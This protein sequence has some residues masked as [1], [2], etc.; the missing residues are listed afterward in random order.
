MDRLARKIVAGAKPKFAMRP[1]KSTRH[2]SFF[3][4]DL[5]SPPTDRTAPPARRGLRRR[6]RW[7]WRGLGIVAAVVLGGLI[8]VRFAG[9]PV[10]TGIVNRKLANLSGFSG[11][12]SAVKLAFWRGATDVDDFTLFA[13]GK[14]DQAPVVRAKRIAMVISYPALLR[15]KVSGQI[16]VEDAE[17]TVVKEPEAAAK[18]EKDKNDGNK[19]TDQKVEETKEKAARWQDVLTKSFPVQITR[20]E[21]KN[22][23]IRLLDPTRQPKVDVG[24]EQFHLLATG[25][26]NRPEGG[27][28]L[29]AKI[30]VE[31]RT[32][33]NGKL[34][35]SVEA[36]PLAKQPL[37]NAKLELRDMSLPPFNSFLL[38]YANADVSRG[39][40]EYYMEVTAAN[41]GYYGYVKPFFKD[42]DFK[43][44][45]DKD[46]NAAQLF[47][48]KAIS[49]AA[50]LL[51]NKEEE[52]V[53]TKVPF[54]GNFADNKVD[55]WTAIQNL[56]H[57]AFVQGLREGLEGEAAAKH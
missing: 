3:S 25:L 15:G 19:K 6:H 16:V 38:A 10:A 30:N 52:K 24:I 42:L 27:G 53:A 13:R 9:S 56:L 31:G 7:L 29:P 57:N 12:V 49:A 4:T 48:K 45:S 28:P 32:T 23:R 2:Q 35:V 36:D 55:I 43:T 54:S 17:L 50:S 11:R 33:G 20:L 8:L 46:K 26:R 22:A 39:T 44:A 18:N 37:F 41:G 34:T 40:F 5:E 51:K 1:S 14:E 47:M 21:L